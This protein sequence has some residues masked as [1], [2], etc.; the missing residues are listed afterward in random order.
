MYYARFWVIALLLGCA[1]A[2]PP[3][4]TAQELEKVFEDL[5]GRDARAAM[6]SKDPQASSDLAAKILA[7]AETVRNEPNFKALLYQ[8]AYEFGVRGPQGYA[9]AIKAM[10]GLAELAPDKRALADEN[11]LAVYQLQYKAAK[12]PDD[13]SKAGAVLVDQ[14]VALADGY[15]RSGNS[16]KA[17]ESCRQAQF[18]LA[19]VRGDPKEGLAARL[20]QVSG[21]LAAAQQVEQCRARIQA[22]PGDK[23]AAENLLRLYLVELDNP[24]EAAKYADLGADETTKK[25]LLVAS[26][27]LDTLPEK[28][29]LELGDW[30]KGLE[31]SAAGLSG[32]AAMLKRAKTYYDRYLEVHA[33]DDMDRMRAKLASAKIEKD[34]ADLVPPICLQE[35]VVEAMIDDNSDLWVTP[36]GIYWKHTGGFS[37]PGRHGGRN[38]PTWVNG[39]PWMP[40][41][42]KP[43]E[44]TG[45]DQSKPLP[46]P[47]GKVGFKFELQAVGTEKGCQGI[48]KR[49]PIRTRTEGEAFVVTIPD[50]Q[51][52]CRWYRFRLYRP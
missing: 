26:M 8:K 20:K 31:A 3:A 42:G 35:I 13:K 51:G 15:V 45:N 39:K 33:A 7:T 52:G 34:L 6:A 17:A 36:Q 11:L 49:D 38:E 24:A 28:A 47:V 18:V 23:A 50:G 29:C 40:E 14:L 44:P 25:Y 12:A 16:A 27:K 10:T 37:K 41:W 43:Q 4:A 22:N 30:F 9:T 5:Y 1:V 32:K 46:L 19:S 2:A 21:R 48:E